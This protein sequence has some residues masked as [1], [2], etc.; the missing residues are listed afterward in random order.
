MKVTPEEYF[1]TNL[2]SAGYLRENPPCDARLV[3]RGE[4][5]HI[6]W[7]FDGRQGD[8]KP[9]APRRRTGKNYLA[10]EDGYLL[11]NVFYTKQ[12]F[13]R[14]FETTDHDMYTQSG[15]QTD[16]LTLLEKD[17]QG[18]L[19]DPRSI[20]VRARDQAL[21]WLCPNQKVLAY[22]I[23]PAGT[24]LHN[25]DGDTTY[26]LTDDAYIIDVL[27]DASEGC[28]L[29]RYRHCLVIEPEDPRF[30]DFQ[31]VKAATRPNDRLTIN[32]N[33]RIMVN[34]GHAAALAYRA[35]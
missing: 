31:S 26:L 18:E 34:S 6:R 10:P 20:R 14:F 33:D 11:N 17:A 15:G 13:E 23:A 22:V 1:T 24:V 30:R 8:D 19:R 7:A 2:D 21:G 9:T 32:E 29:N 28:D 35:S 12:Y 16:R 3:V 27:N 5:V 25:K 4:K